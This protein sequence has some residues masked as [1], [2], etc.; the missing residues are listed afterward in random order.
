MNPRPFYRSRMFWFG[1]PGLLFLLWAW[2]DSIRYA[3]SIWCSGK[4]GIR[5][6]QTSGNAAFD[7][8]RYSH[9]VGAPDLGM[10]RTA[11]TDD[12]A[13]MRAKLLAEVDLNWYLADAK[14]HSSSIHHK[15][16]VLAYVTAWILTLALW[17]RRKSRISKLHTAP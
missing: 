15:V 17:Q 6:T 16:V 5:V 10:N 14:P 4:V 8:W 7:V 1:L 12:A 2:M 3:T 13:R 11:T 9:F